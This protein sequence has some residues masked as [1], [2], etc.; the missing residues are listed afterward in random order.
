VAGGGEK[1]TNIG[2]VLHPP[3]QPAVLYQLL[4][5]KLALELLLYVKEKFV[6]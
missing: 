6:V 2:L 1:Q 4:T 3:A 5:K